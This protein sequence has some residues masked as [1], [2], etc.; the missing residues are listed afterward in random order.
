MFF[1]NSIL[2]QDHAVKLLGS[3]P[4][5]ILIETE[6]P[7]VLEF[8]MLS[9]SRFDMMFAIHSHDD[10]ARFAAFNIGLV[11]FNFRIQLSFR[12]FFVRSQRVISLLLLNVDDGYCRTR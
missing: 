8:K 10:D 11:P 4:V 3:N 1:T 9:A 5:T 7:S 2:S 6:N 12:P